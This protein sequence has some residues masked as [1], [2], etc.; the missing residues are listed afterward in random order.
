MGKHGCFLALLVL[1]AGARAVL[2]VDAEKGKALYA[3]RCAFCH[4]PTGHGD[5]PAGAALKPPPTNFTSPDF[6]KN[7]QP[8]T[9]KAAIENGKP[10][11]A[12]VG[13]MA[14]F[15]AEQIDDLVAYLQTLKPAQ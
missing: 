11:T 14:T 13:F 3:S 9:I 8:E 7:V 6:W 2:G 1:L 5:G 10:N 4:G 15:N 12:M